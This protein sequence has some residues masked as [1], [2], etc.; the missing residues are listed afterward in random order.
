MVSLMTLA[1]HYQNI[2]LDKIPTFGILDYQAHNAPPI[3]TSYGL[4]AMSVFT[5]GGGVDNFYYGDLFFHLGF[6]LTDR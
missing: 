6:T 5:A 2:L 4:F 1:E 3:M